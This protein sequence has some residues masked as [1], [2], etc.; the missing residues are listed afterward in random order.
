MK[1]LGQALAVWAGAAFLL[2]AAPALGEPGFLSPARNEALAPGSIVELRWTSPCGSGSIEDEAEIV[3]SLD[4]GV[5][6]P[7]RVSNELSPCA[8]RFRWR[9]PSLA[10]GRARLALRTGAEGRPETE[11]LTLLSGEFRILAD[12]E[13]RV[14]RLLRRLGEWWTPPE[15]AAR[16]AEDLLERSMS[17]ARGRIVLPGRDAEMDAPTAPLTIRPDPTAAAA[18][19]SRSASRIVAVSIPARPAGAAVPLRL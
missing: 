13:G 14:Q 3:L 12:R 11:A 15:A 8:T 9:V 19:G 18:L 1:R 16:T 10:T 17:P 4:G 2:C 6:F 7:I 5:T